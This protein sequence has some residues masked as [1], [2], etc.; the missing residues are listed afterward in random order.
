[1]YDLEPHTFESF[2]FYVVVICGCLREASQEVGKSAG[3]M[4]GKKKLCDSV[5]V[6]NKKV[7]DK[8]QRQAMLAPLARH[9]SPM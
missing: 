5:S 1:V 4:G 9:N 2:G 6:A 3:L 8:G 7:C